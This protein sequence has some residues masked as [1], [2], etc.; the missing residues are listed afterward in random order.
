MECRLNAEDPLNNFL[1]SPGK[2]LFM[3]EPAGPGIRNDTGIY[4]GFEVS[5][6]Y[7]PIL[8]KLIVW[9]E[10]RH[11]AIERMIRALEDYTL[12]G[13]NAVVS[14]GAKLGD[15]ATV[16]EGAVVTMGTTLEEG[17]I[18]V[19]IPAKVVGLLTEGR[20]AARKHKSTPEGR[21]HCRYVKL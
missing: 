17:A 7:D 20:R 13:M 4:S 3:E 10:N 18:A 14:D 16:G 8:S 21:H 12:V 6:Y 15:F 19:G 1:P 2:I 5:P 11:D 9:G